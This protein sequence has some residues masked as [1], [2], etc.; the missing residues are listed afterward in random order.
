MSK[1][2]SYSLY[3]SNKKYLI[4]ML[5]NLKINK[6]KLPNFTTYI[7]YSEEIPNMYIEIIKV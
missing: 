3:G 6:K 7:Y 2:I 4:G 5:E 1:A